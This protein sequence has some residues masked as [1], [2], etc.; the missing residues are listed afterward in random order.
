MRAHF[1][2]CASGEREARVSDAREIKLHG[3][4]RVSGARLVDDRLREKET[5]RGRTGRIRIPFPFAFDRTKTENV[6]K[7]R[8]LFLSQLLRR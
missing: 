4:C 6:V 7:L 5:N 2:G 3:P 8:N 1:G